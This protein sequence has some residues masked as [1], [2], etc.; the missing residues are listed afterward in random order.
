[1]DAKRPLDTLS[2]ALPV[3]RLAVLVAGQQPSEAHTTPGKPAIVLPDE[4]SS[5][6]LRRH[7]RGKRGLKRDGWSRRPLAVSFPA[8]HAGSY[9]IGEVDRAGGGQAAENEL[10]IKL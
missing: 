4:R 9:H 10:I 2:H 8:S 6:L 7:H 5:L 1:M 3:P